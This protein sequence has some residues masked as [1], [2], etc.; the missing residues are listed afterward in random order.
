MTTSLVTGGAGFIGSHILRALLERGDKV[1]VLDNFSTGKQENLDA[2]RADADIIQADIRDADKVAAALM[3]VDLVF[4]QAAFV[5]VPLSMQTPNACLD[6]N[7]NGT[8][9]LLDEARKANVQRVVFA[10]S[11]AVYG[12][13][14]AFPLTEKVPPEPTMSPYAT[15]K[16]VDEIYAQLFTQSLGL[17]VTALRYFN[18]YGPRQAPGSQ[19][20]AAVPIFI[21]RMMQNKAVTIYG[22]GGQTRDLIY[23]GDVVRAN[24]MAADNKAA[25]GEIFN[26]CTGRETK[27]L[28]LIESL[29]EIFPDAPKPIFDEPRAGDIYRSVGS[30]KKAKDTFSFEA[31]T[32]LLDGMKA[33]AN[34]MN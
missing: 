9:I 19:Y 4:H 33:T 15:S 5:S 11:A 1:R 3:D 21:S 12:E 30:A 16:R 13:A 26:I 27:I 31:K 25:A 22:D 18:V 8:A 28:D 34:W 6:A 24:L 32:M 17:D 2:V 23:V 10:S 20:A 7:V 14:D 29:A